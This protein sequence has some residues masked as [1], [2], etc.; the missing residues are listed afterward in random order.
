MIVI[1]ANIIYT[2]VFMNTDSVACVFKA[3]LDSSSSF[4]F[5]CRA[6]EF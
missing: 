6:G 4:F 3:S 1:S 2:N 5:K